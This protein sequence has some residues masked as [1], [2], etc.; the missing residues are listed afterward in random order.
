[1]PVK[2][3]KPIQ[4]PW[5]VAGSVPGKLFQAWM[6]LFFVLTWA[7]IKR[8]IFAGPD[9]VGPLPAPLFGIWLLD[10]CTVIVLFLVYYRHYK[11][12]GER[13]DDKV[14]QLEGLE[15]KDPEGNPS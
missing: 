6:I 10:F 5:F 3:F 12:V 4:R 7:V 11:G 15:F 8:H 2:V 13:A 9:F 1:M 14:K